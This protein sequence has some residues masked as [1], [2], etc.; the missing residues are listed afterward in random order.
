MDTAYI[1]V[2][3]KATSYSAAALGLQSTVE[4]ETGPQIVEDLSEHLN[5]SYA[6]LDRD[7]I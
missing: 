3:S 1:P 5:I 7:D 4:L 2:E 6:L